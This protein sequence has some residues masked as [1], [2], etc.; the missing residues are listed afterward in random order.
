MLLIYQKVLEVPENLS[1][2]TLSLGCNKKKSSQKAIPWYI[3]SRFW[4]LAN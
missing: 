2:K 3:I 1:I 4:N